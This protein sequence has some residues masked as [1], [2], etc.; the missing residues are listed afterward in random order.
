MEASLVQ[1]LNRHVPPV[2]SVD[3]VSGIGLANVDERIKLICGKPYGLDI[4]SEPGAGTHITIRL[5]EM[6]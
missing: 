6:K 5:P 2:A 3:K 1:S 4:Q